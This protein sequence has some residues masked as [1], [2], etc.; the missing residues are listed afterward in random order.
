MERMTVP[1]KRIDE[2]TTMRTV[3]DANKVRE[4]AMDFYWALKR[5]EDTG[6]EPGEVEQIQRAFEDIKQYHSISPIDRLRELA[7]ADR[8]G[9]LF[10]TQRPY[11][12]EAAEAALEGMKNG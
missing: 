12:C 10:I 1:D 7:Q 5:Y 9:R 11:I 2:H 3:I 8:E 4:H 6:L